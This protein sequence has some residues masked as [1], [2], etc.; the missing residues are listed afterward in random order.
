LSAHRNSVSSVTSYTPFFLLYGRRPRMPLTKLLSTAENTNKFGNRLDDLAEAY[1]SARNQT[2]QSRRYNR[3]R[4][5]RKANAGELNVGDSVLVKAEER[6]TLT[7]RHDPLWEVYRVRHPVVWIRNQTTGKTK[8][9]N[10]E[11]VTLVDPNMD[12]DQVRVRPVRNSHKTSIPSIGQRRPPLFVSRPNEPEP[13][14]SIVSSIDPDEDDWTDSRV[15]VETPT[16]SVSTPTPSGL[17]PDVSDRQ[18]KQSRRTRIQPR[19]SSK[20]PIAEPTDDNTVEI[21]KRMRGAE[22]ANEERS[23][24]RQEV[25]QPMD[26]QDESVMVTNHSNEVPM[27]VSVVECNHGRKKRADAKYHSRTATDR[28]TSGD[29]RNPLWRRKYH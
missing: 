22:Y 13:A 11:K 3:E 14:A 9:L 17:R 10:R 27:L 12:W 20:R 28:R 23:E 26:S 1:T 18:A 2:E 21:R 19:R 15:G 5:A 8:I 24:G 4:L 7:S 16:P 6:L 29:W 25:E